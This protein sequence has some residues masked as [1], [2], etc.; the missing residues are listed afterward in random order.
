MDNFVTNPIMRYTSRFYQADVAEGVGS[1]LRTRLREAELARARS[2]H[3]ERHGPFVGD[4]KSVMRRRLL[5]EEL[6]RS[7]ERTR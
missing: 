4:G 5:A 3:V 2:R 1:I 6:Q 7:K